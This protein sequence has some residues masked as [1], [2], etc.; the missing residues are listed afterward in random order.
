MQSW[1][2]PALESSHVELFKFLLGEME[3]KPPL[4]RE[5]AISDYL[6]ELSKIVKEKICRRW[7]SIDFYN[8][9]LIILTVN[10]F[11][12]FVN[13]ALKFDYKTIFFF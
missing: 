6:H 8:Q 9:V 4:P 3:N 5:K 12:Y 13:F 1:G 10:N 7:E 11:Q 2:Y